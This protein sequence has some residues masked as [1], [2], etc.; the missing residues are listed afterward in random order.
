[1]STMD[2]VKPR[3]TCPSPKTALG[4][5]HMSA[6]IRLIW[7]TFG[8]GAVLALAPTL[9]MARSAQA[10]SDLDKR[11]LEDWDRQARVPVAVPPGPPAKVII[12]K[13]ND[14]MCPGCK[15]WYETL[16]PVLAK[17]QTTP[18]AVR[19]V[20]KDFPWN[21]G[22]NPALKETIPGHEASCAAAAAVRLA[23][24]RGKRD[25]MAE[26]LYAHQPATAPQGKLMLD[27]VKAHASELLGIK[28]FVAAYMTK[29][30][31]IQKDISDGMAVKVNSTPTY[32]INGIRTVKDDG[33]VIPLH[34]LELGI[35]RELQKGARGN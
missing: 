14:F 25:V 33:S 8:L 20:E 35:Q 3:Q 15:Y 17:Y 1:M 34:Y 29:L 28:D 21:A 13:F 4:W 32:F 12:V 19:Y 5:S 22:C 2:R 7:L 30:P 11:F 27:E 23:A 6:R 16:K 9:L 18:G 24:D 10:Q 26:W 31:E